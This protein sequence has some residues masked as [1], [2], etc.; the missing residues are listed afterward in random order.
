MV[1]RFARVNLAFALVLVGCV[2]IAG[3]KDKSPLPLTYTY[4]ILD[5]P[6]PAITLPRF[7]GLNAL[8]N[9]GTLAGFF[10]MDQGY[11][12]RVGTDKVCIP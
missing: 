11:G 4:T 9:N 5:I 12:A 3:A 7:L 2:S 6:A 10:S 1:H 8:A